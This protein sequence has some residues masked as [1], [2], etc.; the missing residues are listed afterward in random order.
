MLFCISQ[1]TWISQHGMQSI[2]KKK[3]LKKNGQVEDKRGGRPKEKTKQTPFT[4][5]EHNLEVISISSETV[6]YACQ[7]AIVMERKQGEKA[8]ACQI[9]QELGSKLVA[10]GLMKG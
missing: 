7:E 2:L 8:E 4:A 6:P 1:K 10:T 3:N 5:G 9:T